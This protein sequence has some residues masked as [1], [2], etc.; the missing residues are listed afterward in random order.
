MCMLMWRELISFINSTQRFQVKKYFILST[1]TKIIIVKSVFFI[2][3]I[4]VWLR[5]MNETRSPFRCI[6]IQVI[7]KSD[8]LSF[9]LQ[10]WC[11]Y[12]RR[13]WCRGEVM[14]VTFSIEPPLVLPLGLAFEPGPLVIL[15]VVLPKP[16]IPASMQV[17]GCSSWNRWHFCV[18]IDISLNGVKP[19][20]L[21]LM[22]LCVLSFLVIY[23]HKLDRR[24]SRQ[25][26]GTST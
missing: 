26:N 18:E 21:L 15:Q 25:L 5:S 4:F 10:C 23:F 9:L 2:F 17:N 1:S 14:E 20:C 7:Y 8:S 19:E 11:F 24:N 16:T 12:L 22:C 6:I 13:V 3:R